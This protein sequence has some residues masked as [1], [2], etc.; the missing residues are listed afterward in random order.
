MLLKP[1]CLVSSSRQLSNSSN[2]VAP[3]IESARLLEMQAA[4]LA[5]PRFALGATAFVTQLALL[6]RAERAVI[7]FTKR[8]QARIVAVSHATKFRAGAEQFDLIGAAMDEALEQETSI[9]YPEV[10]GTRPHI[11]AAHA[12]FARRDGM[13]MATIPLVSQSRAFGALT[14]MRAGNAPFDQN[15]LAQCERVSVAIGPLLQLKFDAERSW[16]DRLLTSLREGARALTGPGR[17]G[18]KTGAGIA[19][20]AIAVL[21]F[22]PVDYRIGAPARVEGAIQRALVAPTDGFLRELH[23]RPGDHVKSGQVLAELAQDDLRLEQRKWGSE[24][25]QHENSAAAALAHADR[26]QFVVNQ[27]R[28]DEARAQLDLASQQ[29]E[30]TRIVAPFDGVVIAGDLTQTL[31][32]PVQRG[33]TLLTI[34]PDQQFRLLIEVDERDI[35]DVRAGA[36]GYLAL[37]ALIGR[38]LAFEV[39]RV[40]PMASTRDSRNFFEVEGKFDGT[41]SDLRPGLQGI[42]KIEAGSRTSAWIWTHR[43]FDWLRLALWSWGM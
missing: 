40:T 30:R 19:V 13:S 36:N 21:A 1:A 38:S 11:T 27:S 43:F 20:V 8:G 16:S 18:L 42:A 23:A 9:C 15:E 4:I 10:S 2:P 31:G 22:V 39:V 26:A 34:A 37:G 3:E 35:V 25:A 41:P 17:L 24:L 6:M 12:A 7:G 28:A 33:E 32:A 29:L 5:Q 14:L